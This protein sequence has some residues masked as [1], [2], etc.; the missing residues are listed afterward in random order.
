MN[1]SLRI[2]AIDVGSNSVHMIVAQ[3]DAD[4]GVTT[5]WRM[6]EMVA[7]GRISFPHKVLP[8]EAMDRVVASLARMKQAAQQREAEKIVAVATSAIR[9]SGNG[10]D[11]IQRIKKD[12]KLYVKVVSARDEAKLIYLGVRSA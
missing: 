8:V 7:L 11:L 2:A 4:G 1:E 10:G 5:L 3:V 12:L 9:E 6:K